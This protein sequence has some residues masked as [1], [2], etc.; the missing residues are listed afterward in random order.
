MQFF[1]EVTESSGVTHE[2]QLRKYHSRSEERTRT[3]KGTMLA[4]GGRNI[5]TVDPRNIEEILSKQFESMA[6]V[7]LHENQC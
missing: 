1:L 6:N 5:G 7:N 2:Q 4:V 3:N